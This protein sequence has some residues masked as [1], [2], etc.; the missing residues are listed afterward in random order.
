M[1]VH[2]HREKIISDGEKIV[3]K[4]CHTVIMLILETLTEPTGNFQLKVLYTVQ[5]CHVILFKV[6]SG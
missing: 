4:I 6:V 5:E 1:N 2:V 3:I